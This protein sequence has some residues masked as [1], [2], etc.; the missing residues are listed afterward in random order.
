MKSKKLIYLVLAAVS[1]A[2]LVV[3]AG[4]YAGQDLAENESSV[5]LVQPEQSI[6]VESSQQTQ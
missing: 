5:G 3:L 4:Y 6:A 2:L 1:L